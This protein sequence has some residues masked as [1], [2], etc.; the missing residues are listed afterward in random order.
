M[1]NFVI[2]IWYITENLADHSVKKKITKRSIEESKKCFLETRDF[3]YT[4][5]KSASADGGMEYNRTGRLA[6]KDL[7]FALSIK[8][9]FE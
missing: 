1:N 7:V 3:F 4:L 9:N 2:S 8:M 5:V 6:V